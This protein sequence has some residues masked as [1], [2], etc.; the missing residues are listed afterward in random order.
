MSG[1]LPGDLNAFGELLAELAEKRGVDRS[2]LVRR[3]V[4]AGWN[5]DSPT[6][7][8]RYACHKKTPSL[9]LDLLCY[10]SLALNLTEDEEDE[11][12]I[13]AY[14]SRKAQK[15]IRGANG[16]HMRSSLISSMVSS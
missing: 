14:R 16:S 4:R 12:L 13:R 9:N 10:V 1:R 2:E 6:D 7:V 11:V 8:L 15:K 5:V 3:M